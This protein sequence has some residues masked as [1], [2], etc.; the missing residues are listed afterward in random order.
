[1]IIL[2]F[3]IVLAGQLVSGFPLVPLLM[4]W[5]IIKPAFASRQAVAEE[6]IYAIFWGA[7]TGASLA[8]LAGNFIYWIVV[9]SISAALVVFMRS[10]IFLALT[11]VTI[12]LLLLIM[13]EFWVISLQSF[14][15]SHSLI[16]YSIYLLFFFLVYAL[17][18]PQK[19]H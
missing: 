16:I 3:L 18:D 7:I 4:F 2:V 15:I 8:I 1:M 14:T 10:Y 12:S 19:N 11:P 6:F 13:V 17:L 5:Q 9:M